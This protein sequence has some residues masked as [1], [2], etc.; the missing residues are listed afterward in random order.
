[1][2]FVAEWQDEEEPEQIVVIPD[3]ASEVERKVRAAQR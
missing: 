3:F 1:M 2:R